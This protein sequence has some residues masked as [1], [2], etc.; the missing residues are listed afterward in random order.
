MCCFSLLLMYLWQSLLVCFASLSCLCTKPRLR[1]D[2]VMLQ[3]AVIAGLIQFALHLVKIP[4]PAIG[5]SPHTLTEPRLCFMVGMIFGS[6]SFFTNSSPH[7]DPPIWPK[8]FELRFVILKDFIPL[9]YLLVYVRLGPLE[10]FD[11]VF[12]S[13][14]RFFDCNPAI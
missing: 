1:R 5:K 14:Q 6:C 9:L 12:L 2:R 7:I 8:D 13:Q 3:Y 10:L 11:I 4:D